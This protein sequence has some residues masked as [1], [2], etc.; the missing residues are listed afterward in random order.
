MD[1][2]LDQLLKE[3][4]EARETLSAAPAEPTRP[5]QPRKRKALETYL[6][7]GVLTVQVDTTLPGVDVP[8]QFLG[9]PLLVLNFSYRFQVTHDLVLTDE[10]LSQT[11]NFQGRAH[12]VRVPLRAILAASGMAGKHQGM[13]EFQEDLDPKEPA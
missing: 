11:L 9:T 12:R 2:D 13:T 3:T 10:E 6:S 4:L 5:P 8:D 1:L 7:G